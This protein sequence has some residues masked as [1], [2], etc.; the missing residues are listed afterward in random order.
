M[1]KKIL[2]TIMSLLLIVIAG[3]GQLTGNDSASS[4]AEDYPNR[5]IDIVIPYASGASADLQARIV[6]DYL[7]DKLDE[8]VNV[9]S[10][11]GGAVSTGQNFIK[12]SKPD[13]Y[14][15]I[16]TAIGTVTLTPN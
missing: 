7:K 13:G 8:T 1:N 14:T 12:V 10:K 4:N 3:C 11:S 6:S 15:I 9:V 2:V 16:L 5:E